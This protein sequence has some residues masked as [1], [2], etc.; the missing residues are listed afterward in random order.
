MD[1]QNLNVIK[2]H[3]ATYRRQARELVNLAKA[4]EARENFGAARKLRQ[5]AFTKRMCAKLIESA[6]KHMQ[7]TV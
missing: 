1:V 2:Q 4:A 5:H 7:H 6:I 3:A